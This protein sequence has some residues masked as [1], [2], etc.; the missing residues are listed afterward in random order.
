[1]EHH[2]FNYQ[3]HCSIS[4]ADLPFEHFTYKAGRDNEKYENEFQDI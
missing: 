3:K 4:S 1:M 2:V